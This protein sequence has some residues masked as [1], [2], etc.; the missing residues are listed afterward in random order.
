MGERTGGERK[1]VTVLFADVAGFTPLSEQMDPEEVSDL[2]RPAVD[3]MSGEVRRFG[4]TI[5]QYLGD[6]I[7]ALFGAPAAHEDSPR[8]AVHAALAI[9]EKLAAY[10][11][12]LSHKDIAFEVR[13]GLNTGLVVT[14][15]VGEDAAMTYTAVGD[16]VNLASR[17]ESTARPGTVQVTE[18]TYRL[19]RDFFDFEDLGGLSVKGVSHPVRALRPLAPREAEPPGGAVMRTGFSQL[20]GRRDELDRLTLLLDAAV[21]GNGRAAAVVGEPGVGKSRLVR[22]LRLSREGDVRFLEGGCRHYGESVAYLPILQVLKSL[23]GLSG[24]EPEEE[25]RRKV[26]AALDSLD[27][28]L[29]V[30]TAPLTEILSLGVDDEAFLLIEPPVRRELAFE[31]VAGLLAAGSRRRP[32]VL[33]M[34]DLHWVDGTSEELLARFLDRVAAMPLLLLLL[35]RPEYVPPWNG[36]PDVEEIRLD[37]LPR[38]DSTR[39]IASLLPGAPVSPELDEFIYSRTAGNPFFME[40]L[41]RSLVE[42]GMVEME[43]GL[44]VLPGDATGPIVPDTVE[45]VIA[46]RIDRLDAASKRTLQVASCIGRRFSNRLLASV[47]ATPDGGLDGILADLKYM[48]FIFERSREPEPEHEFKHALTQDV[49]YGSLLLKKRRELHSAIGRAVEALY[50]GRLEEHYEEL[51]FHFSWGDDDE[52]A[53]GY[54]MLAGE[55]AANSYSMREAVAFY[56]EAKRLLD[57]QPDTGEVRAM[58]LA[59]CLALQDPLALMN[60]PDGS[61]EL[62]EEAEYLAGETG[63]TAALAE[64]YRKS[65]RYFAVR[66]DKAKAVAYSEKSLEAARD[67][68]DLESM[69]RVAFDVCNARFVAGDLL[70]AARTASD[71]MES[72]E[73]G[74][75]RTD[76]H[77]SGT[78]TAYSALAGCGGLALAGLG[79]FGGA[80]EALARGRASARAADDTMGTA[81]IDYCFLTLHFY[82]GDAE[83]LVEGSREA[84]ARFEEIGAGFVLGSCF[85]YLAC[86]LYFAGE[87]AEALECARTGVEKGRTTGLPTNLPLS[88]VALSLAESGSGDFAAAGESAREALALSRIQGSRQFEAYALFALGAAAGRSGPSDDDAARNIREGIRMAR[89]QSRSPAVCHGLVFLGEIL[90]HTGSG[91]EAREALREAET[92]AVE[93]GMGYWLDRARAGLAGLDRR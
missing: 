31:A 76:L 54:T 89:G 61:L 26:R 62:L 28:G 65:S 23:L 40:E 72:L 77:Y 80:A 83:R 4:G 42:G 6:G 9:Q 21:S 75:R 20:S 57:G 53:I 51:A 11:S 32:L 46:S 66:G 41:A 87:T 7:M 3:I 17:M 73:R 45:G 71:A 81:W 60:Y 14:G 78:W 50:P 86:G 30:A 84:I 35:Y 39:M 25:G 59:V 13:I 70:G 34:E 12:E 22:E 85:S 79:E 19:T 15:S 52:K 92:L 91:D 88:L 90:A 1:Q 10:S 63:D 37:Q 47:L 16:T 18:D 56:R 64:I 2:I 68:G 74:G 5:A 38:K 8:R 93:M 24:Y 58:K 33:V 48:E 29:A 36:R 44:L 55:K 49:A 27:A 43:G 82:R 69:A 67:V